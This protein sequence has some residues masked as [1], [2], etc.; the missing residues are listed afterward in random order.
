MK[1][2]LIS[3]TLLLAIMIGLIGVLPVA[4]ASIKVT[5]N[6]TAVPYSNSTG[7]PYKDNK[8]ILMVPVKQ[9]MDYYGVITTEDTATGDA[10]LCLGSEELRIL[11]GQA[12][13]IVN[14]NPVSTEAA[15]VDSNGVL[16]APAKELVTGLG[17]YYDM[18]GSAFAITTQTA[19]S[20]MFLLEKQTPLSEYHLWNA[21][22]SANK[23][24]SDEA[25]ADATGL[26]EQC[27]SFFRTYNDNYNGIS[28]CYRRLA[29]CYARTGNYEK[30]AAAYNRASHYWALNGD[31]Q[32][33]L[34]D[35]ECDKAIREEIS[36][37]L[38][39]SDLSLSL[40][41]THDVNY[42][43]AHGVVLGYTNDKADTY[44]TY[45]AK[46]AGMWLKYFS[47]GD[48]PDEAFRFTKF[49]SLD[50]STVVLLAVEPNEGLGALNDETTKNLAQYL[51]ASGKQ[52][53][54][55]FANEMNDSSCVWYTDN[56]REYI[57]AYIEFAEIFRQYAPEIPLVWSPNFFPENNMDAYYPGDEYVD[58]VGISSYWFSKGFT[59]AE[60]NAGYDVLGTGIRTQRWSQQ[61]DYLYN[62]YGYKKPILISEGA[63]SY[64]DAKTGEAI[65]DYAADM[66]RDTYT[67]LPIRYPNLKYAVYFDINK[68]TTKYKL[69]DNTQILD[70]YN[71][72]V[73]DDIYVSSFMDAAPFCYVPFATINHNDKLPKSDQL[74]AYVKYGNGSEIKAVRYSVNGTI[75]GVATE[76]PY[77]ISYDFS[78]Y[79]GRSVT[80]Q[81]DALDAE[82]SVLT[83]KRFRA[84]VD[85]TPPVYFS[86]VQKPTAYYYVP[87]YW[88]AEAG[89]TNG[90]TETTFGPDR[91]C[92]RAQV[93]TFLWR[94]AGSPEPTITDCAFTDVKTTAF[95]Y[96]AML[97]AVENGITKGLTATTFGPDKTCTR[98]Q[99]VTFLWRAADS[100]NPVS[101]ECSF[102]DVKPADYYYKAV[103]WAV[104][105]DVT[106][107][108]TDT[109][110]GPNGDCTRAQVVTF[111]YRH[112]N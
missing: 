39:T 2:R 29:T 89:I 72:A 66:L 53:M 18:D 80:I 42:E 105:N 10:L 81:V 82:R 111:L 93:V 101:A 104:E 45:S 12:N 91:T 30:A 78:D 11:P 7:Y 99:V 38:K 84:T 33:S 96:K 37:Y 9:T 112:C 74:C 46:Q 48:D 85:G 23:L 21:W 67:Y 49:H 36:L 17:G 106:K 102:T 27:V 108:V 103:L 73:S 60:T 94:A 65:V 44:P 56:P 1:R 51:R 31:M 54:V 4:A 3:C 76:A 100:P 13:I 40:E 43:P 57:D 87:V 15:A 64:V 5:V 35:H 90:V 25:Y 24:Y 41:T 79:A 16:Y 92:T 6:G 8:G 95:Y 26:Y 75:I 50:E 19:D 28:L 70:A 47:Y 86:D 98:G 69:D 34:I 20:M 14:G 32:T 107:G 88:A 62:H 61:L 97:W 83:S 110:F 52:V 58:Y 22:N 59:A 77:T 55:R 68:E 71:A 109:T 63:V